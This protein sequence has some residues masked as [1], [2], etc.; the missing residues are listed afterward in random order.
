MPKNKI[1]YLDL[2]RTVAIIAVIVIHVSTSSAY[3]FN[4]IS[5][6]RWWF[7]ITLDSLSRFAVPAF[8][9]ITGLLL[10]DPNKNDNLPTFFKKRFIKVIIPLILWT[11]IYSAK[12]SLGNGRSLLSLLKNSVS[13]PAE[14]HLWYLYSLTGLY[15]VIPFI[16]LAL[17]NAPKK[18]IEIYLILWLIGST[19]YPLSDKF[20]HL[21]ISINNQYFT[22]LIGYLILGFYISRY[23]IPSF[24]VYLL[25]YF[26]LLTTIIGTYF[27][28]RQ[29]SGILDEFFFDPVAPNII[30]YS[31]GIFLFLKNHYFNHR[32]IRVISRYSLGVYLIHPLIIE[33]LTSGTLGIRLYPSTFT[34]FIGIPLMSVLV[35]AISLFM[36]YIFKKIPILKHLTP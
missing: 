32:I 7:T 16:R 1:K 26:G 4:Q 35:L 24:L 19:L 27:L 13:R 15:L 33:L 2:I 3:Q 5:S 9:M 28:T 20:L 14:Y 34:E 6:T 30:L 18:L 36:V 29:N 11:I 17:K 10:L 23:K 8:L 31:F 12:T 25:S 22:G 21:P